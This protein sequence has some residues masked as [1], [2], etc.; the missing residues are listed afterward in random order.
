MDGILVAAATPEPV[1]DR[2]GAVELT[3]AKLTATAITAT[4]DRVGASTRQVGLRQPGRSERP[5]WS[6]CRVGAGSK[7]G[8]SCGSQ[9]SKAIR[10]ATRGTSTSANS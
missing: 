7:P 4:P 9:L 1:T 3:K 2:L 6:R 10:S 8:D 5:V